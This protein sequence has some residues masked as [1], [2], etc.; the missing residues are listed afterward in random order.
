MSQAKFSNFYKIP[1]RTLEDWERGI[2]KPPDYVVNLLE[3][4]VSYELEHKAK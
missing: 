4:I 2:C 3:K 1:K